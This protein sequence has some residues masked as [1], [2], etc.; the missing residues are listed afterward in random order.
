MVQ[1]FAVGFSSISVF[2]P[3]QPTGPVNTNGNSTDHQSLI[4]MFVSIS[5]INI[6]FGSASHSVEEKNGGN[7][8]SS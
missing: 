8:T 2:F 1:S 5:L 6:G 3:V 7:T 4:N